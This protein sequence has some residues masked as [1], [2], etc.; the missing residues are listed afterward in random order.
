MIASA[1][2]EYETT[3]VEFA[4]PNGGLPA[5]AFIKEMFVP[6]SADTRFETFKVRDSI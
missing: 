1:S 6:R 4:A 2:G 3:L 5:G